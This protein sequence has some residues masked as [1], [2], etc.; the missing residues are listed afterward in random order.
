MSSSTTEDRNPRSIGIDEKTVEEVLK[1]INSEDEFVPAAVAR[2][3]P[4]IAE[5][6]EAVASVIEGGGSVFFAGAGT[7]GRLGVIEAAEM[8][9]TFWSTLSPDEY[10]FYANVNPDVD[11]PR[12]SQSSERR[13][14]EV[15]R[16]DTL[17]FNGYD[18]VAPLY[19]GMDLTEFY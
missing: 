15:Q 11:H 3:I 10:G 17:M 9:P 8:P 2:E 5:A 18:Q 13:I 1:I 14:G 6:A 12:W 4:R 16:R 7:S 19:E